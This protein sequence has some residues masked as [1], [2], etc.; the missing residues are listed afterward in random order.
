MDS[1]GESVVVLAVTLVA[2]LHFAPSLVSA[3]FRS[4][5]CLES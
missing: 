4:N 2:R 5:Y 1:M 3:E